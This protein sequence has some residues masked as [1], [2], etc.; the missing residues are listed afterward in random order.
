I[1]DAY[2]AKSPLGKIPCWED[3]DYTL[4]DSSCIIA[5]LEKAHPTPAIYPSEPKDLGRALWF[6]MWMM[7]VMGF[8]IGVVLAVVRANEIVDGGDAVT[9][10]Q[11]KHVIAGFMFIGFAAVFA[12]ISFAIARILGHASLDTTNRHY[13]QS[14]MISAVDALHEVIEKLRKKWPGP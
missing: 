14:Q 2:R 5:Y 13:N 7:A 6:P 9:I 8:T 1:D 4:A 10:L 3:G 11:L 12:A